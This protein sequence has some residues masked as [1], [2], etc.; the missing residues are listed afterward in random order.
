MRYRSLKDLPFQIKLLLTQ[1]VVTLSAL[2][3]LLMVTLAYG[4]VSFKSDLYEEIETQAKIIEQSS[5]A[6]I[7]FE[8]KAA[9]HEI[10]STLAL[11]GA[12]NRAYLFQANETLLASYERPGAAPAMQT[13]SLP[14]LRLLRSD[15]TRHFWIREIHLDGKVVGDLFIEASLDR[16]NTRLTLLIVGVLIAALVSLMIAFLI[17]IRVNRVLTQP[18]FALTAL[19]DRVT[20]THDYSARCS[21]ASEDELGKLS[22]GMNEMLASIE[23]RDERLAAELAKQTQTKKA[24]D[25]L[26]YYD[27]VTQLP[28]RH[29]FN[30]QLKLRLQEADAQNSVCGLM[31][32]DL[33]DFKVINDTYGHR[34]G[35]QLLAGVGGRLRECLSAQDEV[36]RI[37][38][39]E[40][41]ILL[42]DSASLTRARVLAAKVVSHCADK[43]IINNNDLYVGVSIGVSGYPHLAA[44][45]TDLVRS[46]DSAMYRAKNEGK[47]N[48]KFFSKEI[49]DEAHF[50]SYLE[51][52]LKG[53]LSRHEFEV[54]YQPIVEMSTEKI[55]GFEALLR[56]HEPHY[57]DISPTLFIACAEQIGVINS[58]GEWVLRQACLQQKKWQSELGVDYMMNVNLSGRQMREFDVVEKVLHIVSE[59]GVHPASL[60]IE[61]TESVLMD[62]TQSTISKFHALRAAGIKIS[63]DDFGTGYSSL[64]YLRRFPI[65]TIKIDRSFVKELSHGSEYNAI[66]LAIIGLAKSLKLT[67]VAE[68]VETVEQKEI[69]QQNAC[70]KAQGYLFSKP[71][72]AATLDILLAGTATDV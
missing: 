46:A 23:Q 17:S 40:F 70:D 5:T 53:A 15:L 71:L 44:D 19:V 8:D 35:D 31:F 55:V 50:R 69:L 3:V 4:Y 68:G 34:V 51:N 29:F 64:S 1:G 37:G 67:V 30:Q 21:H 16:L 72:P 52:A 28:N 66:P 42:S 56:W 11:M 33:D 26:A 59:T 7:V 14:A 45:A 41:A 10:L 63:I 60:N 62:H 39:D 58:L 43:F 54:Y 65:N 49:D 38:G 36:F 24:L 22:A 2:L 27:T 9:A 6:A 48:F 25:R 13:V 18:I 61:L 47:N 12:I 57:G 32:I 20:G